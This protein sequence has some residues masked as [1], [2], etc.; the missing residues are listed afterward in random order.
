MDG[1]FSETKPV[2]NPYAGNSCHT[3]SLKVGQEFQDFICDQTLKNFGIPL[4]IYQS[5]RYQYNIGESRQGFEVK[6]DARSTGDCTHY[7]NK[8]TYNVGIE[9]AEKTKATNYSWAPSGIYRSD[10]TWMYVVGNYHQAWY[11]SKKILQKLHQ[12]NRY[13]TCQTLPTI[14]TMLLPIE[15]ADEYACIKLNFANL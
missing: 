1:M 7:E 12:S 4:T 11:F 8:P 10:N 2:E 6:Y 15:A 13:K 14:Q 9:V 5:K 3:D